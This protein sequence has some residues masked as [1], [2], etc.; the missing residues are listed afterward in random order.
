MAK[1]SRSF[2][3]AELILRLYE[4]RR[5]TVMRQARSFVGGGEFLPKS[6]AEILERVGKGGPESAYILQVYGY[7]D[8][9]SAFVKHGSLSEALVYDTC[10]EMYF[11]Y[12]KI[13]PYLK[14][15]RKGL[16]LPE[17]MATLESVIEGSAKGRKRNAAMRKSIE[18][19]IAFRERKPS[20]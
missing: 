19:M 1:K 15:F 2:E 16:Q 11:Q 18:T 5:E 12:A 4:L 10:Q 3:E 20:A 6:A 13:Q 9:V 17:W 8:M 14:E 7:W